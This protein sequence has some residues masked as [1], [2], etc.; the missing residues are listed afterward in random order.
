MTKQLP[1]IELRGVTYHKRLSQET[2]AYTA[3]VWVDG[4][5]LCVVT[6]RGTGGP[7]EF[8]VAGRNQAEAQQA[9]WALD[10]QIRETWPTRKLKLAEGHY[11]DVTPTLELVCG[12]LLTDWL[13]RSE[14]KRLLKRTVVFQ[15]GEPG[16]HYFAGKLDEGQKTE[17]IADL[18]RE[19]PR[20][21]IL[22]DMPF[23][24]AL[25]FFKSQRAS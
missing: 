1:K 17:A 9:M 7:D 15:T 19:C 3:Q 6:N 10:K 18:R 16:N 5:Q 4:V 12:E 8:T 13:C 2:R 20:V 24:E 25:V 11:A 21:K 23:E 14:L 22:N